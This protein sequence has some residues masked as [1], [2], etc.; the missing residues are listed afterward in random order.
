LLNEIDL[1]V[2]QSAAFKFST[3]DFPGK[4]RAPIWR[5]VMGRQ[6]MRLEIE[7]R[8]P[9]TF[10]ASLDVRRLPAAEIACAQSDP[11]VY[12]RT[13]QFANDGNGDFSFNLINHAGYRITGDELGEELTAGDGVLL[14]HGAT[15][16]FDVQSR[17]RMITIR[18]DGKMLRNAVRGLDER[19]F[20]R[21][22]STSPALRLLA[23]YVDIVTQSDMSAD[24]A[25]AH[26]ITAH[27][28]DLIALGLRPTDDIRERAAVGAVPAA[29]LAAI[30]ADIFANL[31]QARLSAKEIAIRQGVSER[32]IYLLFEQNGMSFSRFITEE[33]LKR[34]MA[35]LLD[36]AC[37]H[38]RVGDIAFAVG[39][40]DMTTF[41]RSFRRRY[42]DTPRAIRHGQ[43]RNKKPS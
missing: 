37:A 8:D 38:M 5:E 14:F 29:R 19:L 33:R 6:F 28:I 32:Y 36:P 17:V 3:S 10:F 31:S 22:P 23:G 26:L 25:L 41:N 35:M 12:T 42:G 20:H 13:R 15:G 34:A 2:Q 11:A 40:G 1:P 21:F 43:K 9:D 18:L 27:L 39:F 16:V 24:P 30:R 7:P 4:D